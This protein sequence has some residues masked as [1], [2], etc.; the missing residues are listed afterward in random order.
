MDLK[1][2]L[3]QLREERDRLNAAIS[4]LERL[5]Y[6]RHR[7]PGRPPGLVT[8]VSNN[9]THRGFRLPDGFE[10]ESVEPHAS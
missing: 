5:E 8:K 2:V 3:A 7:G 1:N 6:G 4:N 10:G 9:G